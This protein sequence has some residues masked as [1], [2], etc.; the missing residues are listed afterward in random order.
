MMKF[1]QVYHEFTLLSWQDHP[2]LMVKSLLTPQ[3]QDVA[4]KHI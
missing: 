4:V 2:A 3:F 1:L